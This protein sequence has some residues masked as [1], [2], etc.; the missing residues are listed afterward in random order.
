MIGT[1]GVA[2][3]VDHPLCKHE[4]LVQIPVP[5]KKKKNKLRHTYDSLAYKLVT[6]RE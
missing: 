6:I 3:A 5:P 2:Q 4:T 1:G